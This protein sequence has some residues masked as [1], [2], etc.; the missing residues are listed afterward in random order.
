MGQVFERQ[1]RIAFSGGREYADQFT[2]LSII[3]FLRRR[4]M[5]VI[6]HGACPRGLDR[7]VDEIGSAFVKPESLKRYPADWNRHKRAAGHVRNLFMLKDFR[8]DFL[9]AFPGGPG[10][11]N[12][13]Q[14]AKKLNIPVVQITGDR[15][16]DEQNLSEMCSRLL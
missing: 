4:G 16:S 11:A 7:L 10:T 2:V 6:C 15:V 3:V 9:V 8:P 1:M 5:S 14:N 13:V 12:C